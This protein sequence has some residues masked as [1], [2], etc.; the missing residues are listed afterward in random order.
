MKKNGVLDWDV[1]WNAP[2]MARNFSAT[3]KLYGLVEIKS[4]EQKLATNPHSIFVGFRKVR[5][6]KKKAKGG[7]L[8]KLLLYKLLLAN[9]YNVQSDDVIHPTQLSIVPN[10]PLYPTWQKDN[11]QMI[12]M[13]FA[14][15]QRNMANGIT[16]CVIDT[17]DLI[18]YLTDSIMCHPTLLKQIQSAGVNLNRAARALPYILYMVK[19]APLGPG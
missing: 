3:L 5:L 16:V 2:Q 18:V 11:M 1:M 6:A 9:G 19:L 12:E 4:L 15:G 7:R 10:D 13:Q 17:G 8:N 14:W